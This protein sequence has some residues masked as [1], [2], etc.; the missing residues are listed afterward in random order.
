MSPRHRSSKTTVTSTEGKT[1][2]LLRLH[3]PQLPITHIGDGC[4]MNGC[5]NPSVCADTAVAAIFAVVRGLRSCQLNC[6]NL[7]RPPGHAPCNQH[8]GTEWAGDGP[9]L[10]RL[11]QPK[12]VGVYTPCAVSPPAQPCGAQPCY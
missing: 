1:L 11:L 8:D 3:M 7:S 6:S 2:A 10:G 9:A 12:T 4:R 5:R